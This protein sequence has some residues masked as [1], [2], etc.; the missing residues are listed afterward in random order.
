LNGGDGARRFETDAAV[1]VAPFL[2]FL[3]VSLGQGE[4]LLYQ[5]ASTS[6]HYGYFKFILRSFGRFQWCAPDHHTHYGSVNVR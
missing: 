2:D 4:L 5:L 3:I 1:S 6:K